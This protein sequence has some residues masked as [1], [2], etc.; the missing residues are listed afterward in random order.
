MH[1]AMVTE[2]VNI[3]NY[4][5]IHIMSCSLKNILQLFIRQ[6]TEATVQTPEFVLGEEA[7]IRIK[8][9][10]QVR[11]IGISLDEK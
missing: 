7:Q 10:N 4:Y 6:M 5:N 3:S 2:L 11:A 1:L 9:F 8:R